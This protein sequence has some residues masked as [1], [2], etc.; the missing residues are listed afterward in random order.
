VSDAQKA[1]DYINNEWMRVPM[2]PTAEMLKRARARIVDRAIEKFGLDAVKAA[3][4]ILVRFES[5]GD[6]QKTM[7]ST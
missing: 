1:A 5:C 2:M 7:G 6:H 3:Q 4:P